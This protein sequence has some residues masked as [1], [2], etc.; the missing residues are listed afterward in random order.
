MLLWKHENFKYCGKLV[1]RFAE[2]HFRKVPNQMKTYGDKKLLSVK[3]FIKKK[4]PMKSGT[5][6]LT[7]PKLK[8]MEE[9][10]VNPH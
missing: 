7:I 1:S 2:N 4:F 5:M 9:G 10:L 8:Q 6:S 3:S